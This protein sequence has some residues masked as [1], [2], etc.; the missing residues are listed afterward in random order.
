MINLYFSKN[1]DKLAIVP[2]KCTDGNA[3]KFHD[4]C[5][6]VPNSAKTIQMFDAL[7]K[8]KTFERFKELIINHKNTKSNWVISCIS[9]VPIDLFEMAIWHGVISSKEVTLNFIEN[10]KMIT[11]LYDSE[12]NIDNFEYVYRF[13]DDNFFLDIKNFSEYL[14]K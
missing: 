9:Y 2:V 10:D 5:L 13:F 11:L 7:H 3:W 4:G 1:I 14:T 6:F 8:T 12:G